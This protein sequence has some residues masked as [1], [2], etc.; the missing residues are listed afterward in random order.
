MS[1]QKLKLTSKEVEKLV[2]NRLN[3]ERFEEVF[4]DIPMYHPDHVMEK[5]ETHRLYIE[6]DNRQYRWYIFKDTVTGVE[7][8]IN[9]TYHPEFPNDVMDTPDSIEIV[10]TPEESDIYVKPVPVPEPA[11]TTFQQTIADLWA[12]YKAIASECQLVVPKQKLNVP[13]AKIDEV[14]ALLKGSYT[15][16]DLLKLVVPI[17][18]EYRIEEKSFWHW[19]QVKR[20]VWKA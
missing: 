15:L 4:D 17:C 1:E 16:P 13:K 18:I 14:L 11:L 10:E 7:H 8:C 5:G 19:L 2:N 20:K 6:D 9:Y 12:P 3:T